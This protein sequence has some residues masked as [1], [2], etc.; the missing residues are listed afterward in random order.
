[1][2]GGDREG[3]LKPKFREREGGIRVWRAK[4]KSMTIIIGDLSGAKEE[5]F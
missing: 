3:D 5:R 4:Y 2:L 1:M